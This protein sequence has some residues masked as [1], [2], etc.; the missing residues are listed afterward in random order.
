MDAE[1]DTPD[2]AGHPNVEE[3]IAKPA[4]CLGEAPLHTSL[5]QVVGVELGVPPLGRGPLK[6]LRHLLLPAEARATACPTSSCPAGACR[7]PGAAAAGGDA[8]LAVLGRDAALVLLRVD[9]DRHAV[10]VSAGVAAHLGAVV[11]QQLLVR[12]GSHVVS[13]SRNAG[14][15]L[16]GVV[17]PKRTRDRD[18]DPSTS[19]GA[20]APRGLASRLRARPRPRAQRL[21]PHAGQDRRKPGPRAVPRPPVRGSMGRARPAAHHPLPAQARGGGTGLSRMVPR[22]GRPTAAARVSLP[23]PARRGGPPPSGAGG[24]APLAPSRRG[25]GPGASRRL[26]APQQG[27]AAG[28]GGERAEPPRPGSGARA[29]PRP[30]RDRRPR[31]GLRARR[32]GPAR[33]RGGAAR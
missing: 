17:S 7:L 25:L 31:S 23:G 32:R 22:R 33:P 5:L 10:A 19:C 6:E 1:V 20:A 27:G 28:P 16:G 13:S 2:Q 18:R 30:R 14:G 9:S 26:A 3:G 21:V 24:C 8:V 15:G 29:A 12:R 11:M 4:L